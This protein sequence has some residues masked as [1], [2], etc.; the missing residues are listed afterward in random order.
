MNQLCRTA[1]DLIPTYSRQRQCRIK[2]QTAHALNS[3]PKISQTV[4]W[5]NAFWP[6]L[7]PFGPLL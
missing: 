6:G 2:I 5:N 1:V 4:S 7:A 3:F